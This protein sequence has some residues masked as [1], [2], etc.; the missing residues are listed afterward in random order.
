M[1]GLRLREGGRVGFDRLVEKEQGGG[2][3]SSC[4]FKHTIPEIA[5][6]SPL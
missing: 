6:L 4:H 3:H 2:G 1:K 5:F